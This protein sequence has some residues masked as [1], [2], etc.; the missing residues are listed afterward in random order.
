[1]ATSDGTYDGNL[2]PKSVLRLKPGVG[3]AQA[4]AAVQRVFQV[5]EGAW[6]TSVRGTRLELEHLRAV[7]APVNPKAV[8]LLYSAAA[9]LL[10]LTC[11]NVASLFLDRALG[12]SREVAVRLA[13]G[14]SIRHLL[15]ATILE[16]LLVV[17]AGSVLALALERM[18]RPFVMDQLPELKDLGPELLNTDPALLGFALLSCL[19]VTL[20]VALLPALQGR[21]PE[22]ARSLAQGSRATTASTPWRS[23]LVVIQM[24]I[25]LVLLTVSGLVGRSFVEALRVDPGFDARNVLTSRVSLPTRWTATAYELRGLIQGLPGTESVSFSS[26]SPLEERYSAPFKAGYGAWQPEDRTFTFKLVG[27]GYFETLGARLAGGRTFTEDEVRRFGDV[28]ILNTHAARLLFGSTDPVGRN[29]FSGVSDRMTTVVG[30]VKDLRIAGLDREAPPAVYIPYAPAYRTLAFHV[31]TTASLDVFSAA[32][33]LRTKAL[34]AGIHLRTFES[35]QEATEQTIRP[36]LRAVVL[37]GGFA[38]LGLVIGVV[39]LY[40]TLSSQV[41]QRRQEI[42]IRLAIGAAPGNVVLLFLA[43]GGRLVLLGALAGLTGSV[44]AGHLVQ[45]ELFAVS[46]LDAPSFVLALSLLLL[47]ALLA[48]LLPALRAARTVPAEILRNE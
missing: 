35:L 6:P 30:V 2:T 26:E 14:A 18:A 8:L 37:V 16:S 39:G 33:K 24:A 15:Q 25:I 1:M 48:C 34:N 4:N 45:R 10:M 42:G 31:R 23:S 13:L 11:A 29:L 46:P 12:R 40:G 36:R 27:S 28:S 43:R 22:L 41:R 3:L 17:G 5:A 7:L 21:S 38:L 9:L 20:A 47:A 19:L 44:V 32:L